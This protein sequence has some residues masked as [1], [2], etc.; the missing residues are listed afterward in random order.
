MSEADDLI[1]P[2]VVRRNMIR[3]ASSPDAL[4][5]LLARE[6]GQ[7][8]LERLLCIKLDPACFLDASM[9]QRS[10]LDQLCERYP[11]A[12]ALAV[13]ACLPLLQRDV[14][15]THAAH[16]GWMNQ[17]ACWRF[18]VSALSSK[19]R[20]P[21]PTPVGFCADFA[22]LPLRNA[23]FDLIWSNL[24]LHWHN[25]PDVVFAEWQRVLRAQ[26]LVMF[27]CF[28]PDTFKELRQAL[29]ADAV[30]RVMPL[31]D[32]HDLGDQLIHQGFG[33]PVMDMEQLTLTYSAPQQLLREAASLGGN[34]LH[35]RPRGMLSRRRYQQWLA[36]VQALAGPDGRI[37][38]T[39]EVIYGHAWKPQPKSGKNQQQRTAEGHVAIPLAQLRG[40]RSGRA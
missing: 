32:M 22:Q 24:A 36:A 20:R 1:D 39:I 21:T 38:L 17:L 12:A 37:P 26:G 35:V 14:Q 6:I 40:V 31:I 8:M 7:R 15:K 13:N 19:P 5:E 30:N 33:D 29:G 23:S 34:P 3:R 4:A 27:S 25:H 9:S 16:R 10:L 11:Q 28:G 18:V 2:L